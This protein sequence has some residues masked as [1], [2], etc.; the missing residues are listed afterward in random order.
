MSAAPVSYATAIIVL[1]V[2]VTCAVVLFRT[3]LISTPSMAVIPNGNAQ[4]K[5]AADAWRLY[6]KPDDEEL[7][8]SLDP[9]Q[10]RVTRQNGTEAPFQNKYW[11]HH[12]VGIYVDVV[13]GEPLFSSLDKFDSGTGW[14]SF[15]RPLVE[16][17]VR[18]HQDRS[19]PMER[20]EVRSAGADSHLGHLFGDGPPPTGMRYCINSAA[21]RFVRAAD[22]DAK[23]YGQFAT[24][25][26]AEPEELDATAES[27]ERATLAGGCFWGMEDILR[28][29]PGVLDTQVGYTGGALDNPTYGDVK[30]GQSG[31]AESICLEFDPKKISYEEILGYFFRMHDPTTVDRQGNDR[32]EQYRSAIFYHNDKQRETAIRVMEEVDR[33]GKWKNP[34]AT[35]IVAAGEWFDAEEYHQDYLVNNP[36]GYSCH[37]LRE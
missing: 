16:G 12:D 33:S 34:I 7:R 6:E 19:H 32:G 21:L 5:S 36:G 25:F 30:T 29:I 1:I 27:R 28:D 14:P 9:I 17:N 3:G 4:E 11:D 15:T 18:N 37:F 13:S 2:L 20:I 24:L 23:G 26:T 10:F 8:K 31:H 35:E 22:L